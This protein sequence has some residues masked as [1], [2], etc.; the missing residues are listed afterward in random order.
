M[1][2]R[3]LVIGVYLGAV[4]LPAAFY[5]Q[6]SRAPCPWNA[7]YCGPLD[8]IL[9][10][11]A[12]LRASALIFLVEGVTDLVRVLLSWRAR[13]GIHW[14]SVLFS[15]GASL[16]FLAL[17]LTLSQTALDAYARFY[18]SIPRGPLHDARLVL[19][20]HRRLNQAML[21]AA[22]VGAVFVGMTT[23]SVVLCV[24]DLWHAFDREELER[25]IALHERRLRPQRLRAAH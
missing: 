3:L 11:S 22:R 16:F 24:L 9:A 21:D 5:L 15:I 23:V 19:D 8:T 25:E 10:A 2:T 1:R 6:A 20:I 7:D 4:A 18:A 12:I 14:P 13:E 17:S